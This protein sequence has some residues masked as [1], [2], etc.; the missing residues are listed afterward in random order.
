M[1]V[2]TGLSQDGHFWCQ[3]LFPSSENGEAGEGEVGGAYTR[4]QDELQATPAGGGGDL[5]TPVF[6]SEGDMCAATFS[7]DEEWYR[8]KIEKVTPGMV[9]NSNHDHDFYISSLTTSQ[10]PT[11]TPS[12]PHVTFTVRYLDFGNSEERQQHHLKVLGS[13]FKL[14]PPGAI[15]CS[16]ATTDHISFS[17]VVNISYYGLLFHDD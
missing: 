16:I 5:F 11:L 15:H 7:E 10:P 3:L 12:Q 17:S 8:A 13:K 9:W 14:L 2:A 1:V 6:Y 4:L